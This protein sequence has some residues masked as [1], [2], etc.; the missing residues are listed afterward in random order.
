MAGFHV[1][2]LKSNLGAFARGYLFNIF[3]IS[4]PVAVTEEKISYLVRASSVPES[5][6]D[7]IEVPWQGQMY[8]I[9]ST[10]TFSE[11]ECTFNVDREASIL[12]QMHEWSRLIHDPATNLQGVPSD[13]FGE[14]QIEQLDVQNNVISTFQ[15]HQC[16]PSTVGAID[17]AHDNKDIAQLSCTFTYNWHTKV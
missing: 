15:L 16:W 11:W 3:F 17:L 12:T 7:P 13:Y 6:I 8:K 9:G 5:T 2:D 10:H 1:N 14:I 4:A